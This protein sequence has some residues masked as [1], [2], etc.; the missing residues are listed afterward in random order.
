MKKEYRLRHPVVS[1]LFYP[2]SGEELRREIEIYL[3]KVDRDGLRKL[4]I[5]QTGLESGAVKQPLAIIAPHAGYMFSGN[6]QA[7]S[8]A[9]LEGADYETLVV[10][11]PAHQAA[12]K[13]VSISKDD[14]YGTPIGEI[15]V[16]VQFAKELTGCGDLFR[17]FE[18]AHLGEHA[19]EVQIPFIQLQLPGVKIVP[20]LLG[21]QNMKIATHLKDALMTVMKKTGRRTLVVASTDLSHYHSHVDAQNLDAAVIDAVRAVDPDLLN[22]GIQDGN[23]E[24]CGYGGILACLHLARELGQGK[25][26]ILRYTDSGEVSGD[27]RKV[28]G[29]LSAVLY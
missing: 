19:I 7:W 27:N 5:E 1:G 11:G 24:A 26:A 10:I 9:A 18:D 14:A 16:D 23:A 15:E 4:I 8:Y 25:A 13:G 20:I 3:E 29:Y 21:E 22:A 2:D 12:F 28:V 6:V 17:H